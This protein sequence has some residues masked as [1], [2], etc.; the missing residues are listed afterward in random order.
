MF[1][2]KEAFVL[3]VK[4]LIRKFYPMNYVDGMKTNQFYFGVDIF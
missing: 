4:K 1:K 2:I 3:P